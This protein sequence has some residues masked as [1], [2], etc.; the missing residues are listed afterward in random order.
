MFA[1]EFPHAVQECLDDGPALRTELRILL[2][3]DLCVPPKPLTIVVLQVLALGSEDFRQRTRG[4]AILRE[5][6]FEAILGLGVAQAVAGIFSRGGVD[7]RRAEVVAIDGDFAGDRRSRGRQ[8]KHQ[9]ARCGNCAACQPT[10]LAAPRSHAPVP[11][12][13]AHRSCSREKGDQPI[14][15]AAAPKTQI[16][17]PVDSTKGGFGW[18][19][20]HFSDFFT[21]CHITWR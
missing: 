15:I 21:V 2:S 3:G 7:V 1:H 9:R 18:A 17:V 12:E 6:F 13:I 19:N 10:R 4:A 11:R 8:P 14:G 5:Q 20:D 16:P